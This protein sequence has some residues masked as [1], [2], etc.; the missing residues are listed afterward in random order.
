MTKTDLLWHIVRKLDNDIE[1]A[2]ADLVESF[3][4]HPNGGDPFILGVL[5]GLKRARRRVGGSL[6]AAFETECGYSMN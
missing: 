2:E 5:W 1:K 6:N 4:T 3:D